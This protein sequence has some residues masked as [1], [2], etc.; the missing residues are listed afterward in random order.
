MRI[1]HKPN[2]LPEM[3]KHDDIVVFE[4]QKNKGKWHEAFGSRNPIYIELGM[5]RG[6]FIAAHAENNPDKNYIGLE[7]KNEVIIVALRKVLDKQLRNIMLAPF[8]VIYL[9]EAFANGEVDKIFLNF[10][11]P[12]PKARHAKRRLTYRSFLEKYKLILNKDGIIEFKTDN[13]AL[14]DFSLGEFKD[15]GFE[16]TDITYDLNS[17]NDPNNVTTEYEEKFTEMGISICRLIAKRK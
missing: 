6:K 7:K 16:L 13:K 4:P 3:K 9:E 10:S 12:W 1:R 2:A 11:D 8:N 15:S 14:F 17:L 5:G